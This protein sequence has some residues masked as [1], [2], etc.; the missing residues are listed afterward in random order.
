MREKLFNWLGHEFIALSCEGIPEGDITAETATV[1]ARFDERLR[2]RGLSLEDTV[3]TRLW[4]RDM[5]SWDPGVHERARI[6]GGKARSVSSSHIRPGRFASAGHIAVDLLAMRPNI[7]A[8]KRCREY[9]PEGI[10]LR[11]L[12]WENVVFLSGVTVILPTFEAQ[13]PVIIGRITDSLADAG[14]TWRDVARASF[15]LHNSL[16]FTQLRRSFAALVE[17]PLSVHIPLTEY[18]SVDTRQGKLV[19]IEITAERKS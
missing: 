19:E 5:A 17:A 2:A 8:P 9:E 3:R 6:L 12:D 4:A 10:V 13:L 7:A 14:L 15:F 11:Y 1:F 16:D 18:A